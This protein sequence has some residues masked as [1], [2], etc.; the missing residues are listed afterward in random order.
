MDFIA[1]WYRNLNLKKEEKPGRGRRSGEVGE[2]NEKA[3]SVKMFMK[4]QK[5]SALLFFF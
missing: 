3:Y 2:R 1:V 4:S 5:N